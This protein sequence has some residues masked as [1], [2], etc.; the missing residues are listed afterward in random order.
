LDTP[1]YFGNAIWSNAHEENGWTRVIAGLAAP[2]RVGDGLFTPPPDDGD[3][4]FTAADDMSAGSTPKAGDTPV[5]VTAIRNRPP[6]QN[7]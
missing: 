3:E 7:I 5:L 1:S 2:S 4:A 6:N